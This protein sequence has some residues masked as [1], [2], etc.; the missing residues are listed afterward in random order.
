[1]VF[2]SNDTS[3]VFDEYVTDNI[4][5]GFPGDN[6]LGDGAIK[7]RMI[8]QASD[9]LARQNLKREKRGNARRKLFSYFL[10]INR[11]VDG[12]RGFSVSGR[13]SP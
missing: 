4:C 1:M 11:E 5:D 12:M 9:E 3:D 8:C 10:Q 7:V 13:Q 6:L 2:Y